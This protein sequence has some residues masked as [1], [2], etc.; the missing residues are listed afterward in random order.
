MSF[1]LHFCLALCC[2]ARPPVLL[3]LSPGDGWDAVT[4]YCWATIE[5]QGAGVKYIGYQVYVW[6]MCLCYLT[7]HA[8]TP[9][10][11]EKVMVYYY[12]YYYYYQLLWRRT[13]NYTVVYSY[14]VIPSSLFIWIGSLKFVTHQNWITFTL[15]EGV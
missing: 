10:W 7:C 14:P 12:Y 9:W 5:N 13:I 15:C 4:W 6:W 11:R 8:Y 2:L 3:W 1:T